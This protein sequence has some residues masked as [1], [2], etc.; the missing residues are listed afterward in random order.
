M[1]S[2]TE[3]EVTGDLSIAKIYVS[4]L[5]NDEE[6]EETL[7]GLENAK[8]FIRKSISDNIELRHS[9]MPEFYLDE[10]IEQGM[11]ISELISKV[12]KNEWFYN[13]PRRTW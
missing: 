11:R 2:V 9:P 10:S 12:N 5:G 4:V 13:G 3:V 6:K 1:T 7:N 8:G